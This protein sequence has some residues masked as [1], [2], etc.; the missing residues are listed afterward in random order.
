[1]QIAYT[2][3]RASLRKI[4]KGTLI[5]LGSVTVVFLGNHYVEIIRSLLVEHPLGAAFLTGIA[6]VLINS[7]RE[8]IA[9]VSAQTVAADGTAVVGKID[10]IV[11]DI[12]EQ[13]VKQV[14]EA[15]ERLPDPDR[16]P[17]RDGGSGE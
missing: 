5:S 12:Q 6:G 13:A 10:D 7:V 9:G 1:M 11:S 15:Q 8:F 3:D 14:E 4:G 17:G 16:A 2:L